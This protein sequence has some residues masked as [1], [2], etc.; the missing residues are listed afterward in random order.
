MRLN[1]VAVRTT[2]TT[3]K[4]SP[5]AVVR[6]VADPGA[7]ATVLFLGTVRDF[8]DAGEVHDIVYEA[9]LPLARKRLAEIARRVSKEYPVSRVRIVHRVGKLDLQEVSVAIGV[10]SAHRGEAFEA[11]KLAIDLIKKVVPIWKRERLS[12]GSKVWTEGH[13]I[14]D[15]KAS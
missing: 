12:T 8:G 5:S 3:S 7:G 15:V 13:V 1:P 4:I 2:I 6:F 10:S 14:L 9:Y 11:C